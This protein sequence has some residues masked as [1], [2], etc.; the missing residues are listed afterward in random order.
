MINTLRQALEAL[1]MPIQA[2]KFGQRQD[3]IKSLKAAIAELEKVEP[4][5][6]W[7]GKANYA[8]AWEKKDSTRDKWTADCTIPLY[9]APVAPAGWKIKSVDRDFVYDMTT[10]EHTPMVKVFFEVDDY[11]SR[12][13]FASMLAAAP[14]YGK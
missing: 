6:W 12:D 4:D 3:A 14:E 2:H 13:D 7:N 11:D 1:D 8:L 5:V 9:T 10:K